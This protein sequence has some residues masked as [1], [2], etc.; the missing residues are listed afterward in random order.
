MTRN[1]IARW[2]TGLLGIGAAALF[3]SSGSAAQAASAAPMA[4]CRASRC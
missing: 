3:A 4:G 1:V 2:L